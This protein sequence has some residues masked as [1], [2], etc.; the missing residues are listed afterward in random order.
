MYYI[1][2]N[3][4]EEDDG[5]T[6]MYYCRKC[7]FEDTE[8]S[9]DIDNLYVSK[10]YVSQTSNNKKHI[11]NEYTKYD[12]T[13][14]RTNKIICPNDECENH[15]KNTDIKEDTVE[16]AD[17]E[18]SFSKIEKQIICIRYDDANMKY[19]YLC[20]ICDTSWEN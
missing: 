20:P 13:L 17:K 11:I 16:E 8:L 15:V 9:N 7:N 19:M 10:T 12:P 4:N 5:E 2:L 14:P 3:K 18:S 1:K 6:L